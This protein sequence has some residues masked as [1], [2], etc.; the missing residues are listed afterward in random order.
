VFPLYDHHFQILTIRA[1]QKHLVLFKTA[2]VWGSR[3]IQFV[4]KKGQGTMNPRIEYE[5]EK[6]MTDERS[7]P[8]LVI[9]RDYENQRF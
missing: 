9:V 3:S 8:Q 4:T 7:E 1:L 2:S 6:S 5:D